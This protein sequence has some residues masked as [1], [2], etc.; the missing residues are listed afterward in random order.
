MKK[1]TIETISRGGHKT[2]IVSDSSQV[3]YPRDARGTKYVLIWSSPRRTTRVTGPYKSWQRAL[4]TARSV[5]ERLL[6]FRATW[7]HLLEF[8][9]SIAHD[10][11]V[12]HLSELPS[13]AEHYTEVQIA[14]ISKGA[15]YRGSTA[16][17]A[18]HAAFLDRTLTPRS[19]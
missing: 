15:P 10:R 5:S 8:N 11:G 1:R 6:G 16:L 19:G 13:F 9:R 18:A 17:K 3:H 12:A 7:N 2:L 14:R 4:I